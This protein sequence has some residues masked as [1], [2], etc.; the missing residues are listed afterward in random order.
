MKMSYELSL[1]SLYGLNRCESLNYSNSYVL[2]EFGIDYTETFWRNSVIILVH[3]LV[4]RLIFWI[5]L[6]NKVNKQNTIA[7]PEF[8]IDNDLADMDQDLQKN[9]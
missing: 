4:Y 7:R 3:F 1:F 9:K 6:V 2:D 5:I 8:V